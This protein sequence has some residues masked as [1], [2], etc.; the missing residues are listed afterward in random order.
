MA[1]RGLDHGPG[2][3]R[4]HPPSA[5]LAIDLAEVGKAFGDN[6]VLDGLS[7]HIRRGEFLAIVGRSGCG[8]STLLRLLAG[9]DFPTQGSIAAEGKRIAAQ[10]GEARIM[11]QDARLLPWRRVLDNVGI[12]RKGAWHA[13]ALDALHS[14][15][16]AQRAGDWPGILSGGQRQRVALARAL[17]S[18][19]RLLLL[20]EPLGAL[21]ALTRLEMQELVE[22]VWQ[23]QGFTAVL[24]THDVAEAVALADRV[25]VL[26]GGA[27][28]LEQTIAVARPR[29]RGSAELAIVEGAILAQLTNRGAPRRAARPAIAATR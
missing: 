1:S 19:P 20:D 23:D 3:E 29:R 7:L 5:G 4:L 16:L 14:V 10:I 8:K 15:G 21:D 11:F 6:R 22:D 12:G 25:I 27:V 9:L 18:R 26:E 17:V 28:A 2:V 24:V 13:A